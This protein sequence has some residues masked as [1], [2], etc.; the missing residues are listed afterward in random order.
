MG[1]FDPATNA[2]S[3]VSISV[4]S[5]PGNFEEFLF[6]GGV[7]APNGKVYFIPHNAVTVG[8]FDPAAHAFSTVEVIHPAIF[9]PLQ[10]PNPKPQPS[11]LSLP[12]RSRS[13]H[14]N[15]KHQPR[16]QRYTPPSSHPGQTPIQG[17]PWGFGQGVLSPDGKLV[18]VPEAGDQVGVFTPGGAAPSYTVAEGV[19]E[20]PPRPARG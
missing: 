11:A 4:D 5:S 13:P 12:P 2:F 16:H 7:L 19:P 17:T 6:S 14:T 1:V 18:L 9:P 10:T 20:A 15:S 3:V 8:V